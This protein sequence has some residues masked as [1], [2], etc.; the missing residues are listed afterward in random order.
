MTRRL[1]VERAV[2]KFGPVHARAGYAEAIKW[3]H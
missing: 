1:V 2:A 3:L